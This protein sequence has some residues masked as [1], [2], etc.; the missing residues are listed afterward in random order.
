MSSC[1]KWVTRLVITCDNWSQ[2]VDYE[3]TTVGG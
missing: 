2:K 1:T 3:C